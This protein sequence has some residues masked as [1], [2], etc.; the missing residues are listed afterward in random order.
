MS[1]RVTFSYN[2]KLVELEDVEQLEEGAVNLLM[3]ALMEV[4]IAPV[5]RWGDWPL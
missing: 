1:L 2:L 3:P 4:T 5:G